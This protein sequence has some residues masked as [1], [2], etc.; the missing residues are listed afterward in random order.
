MLTRRSP[1]KRTGF[2]RREQQAQHPQDREQ[3]LMDRAARLMSQVRPRA[4][5][6]ATVGPAPAKRIE[7]EAPVRSEAYRRLVAQLPCASCGIYGYSQHA[8]PNEGKGFALKTDDRLGFPLCCA[9]P[10]G[11]EGCHAAFDQYRLLPGGRD[12]H[13]EAARRWGEQTRA[14]ILRLGLWPRNLPMPDT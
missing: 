14:E 3:R 1:L 11:I 5:V 9:R 2:A 6:V 4:A 13:R 12:A 10:G 7:K 8:H